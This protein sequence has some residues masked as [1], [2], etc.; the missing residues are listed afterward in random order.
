[1]PRLFRLDGE[2]RVR[3][4]LSIV[5]NLAASSLPKQ[6]VPRQP[7]YPVITSSL[8]TLRIPRIIKLD[9]LSLSLSFSFLFLSLVLAEP[10]DRIREAEYQRQLTV[11]ARQLTWFL[12]LSRGNAATTLQ[13][14]RLIVRYVHQFDTSADA[15]LERTF[16]LAIVSLLSAIVSSLDL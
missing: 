12:R 5:G 13:S 9:S 8:P 1:M 10:L 7:I 3:R 15:W 2:S 4:V 16:W 14:A 6:P 11:L